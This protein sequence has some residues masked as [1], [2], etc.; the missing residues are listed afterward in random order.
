M[1]ELIVQ[2]TASRGASY[3]FIVPRDFVLVHRLEPKDAVY[4]SVIAD[5]DAVL[6]RCFNP[7][8]GSD[9]LEAP[10]SRS[11]RATGRSKSPMA[12]IPQEYHERL[13]V[14]PQ[15]RVIGVDVQGGMRLYRWTE[16]RARGLRAFEDV[17][18]DQRDMLHA[19]GG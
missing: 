3:G 10:L 17:L 5:D 14:V 16:E 19:L 12:I 1:R 11:L 7:L 13:G 2:S 18:R 6:M 4:F 8:F 15:A 9:R